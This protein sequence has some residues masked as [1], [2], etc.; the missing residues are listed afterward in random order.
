[1]IMVHAHLVPLLRRKRVYI[2]VEIQCPRHK[3]VYIIVEIQRAHER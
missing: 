1:M 3:R 2:I